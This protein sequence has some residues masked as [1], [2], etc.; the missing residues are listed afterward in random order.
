MFSNAYLSFFNTFYI[1]KSIQVRNKVNTRNKQQPPSFL[2]PNKHSFQ[3]T[4]VSSFS[5]MSFDNQQQQQPYSK[6]LLLNYYSESLLNKFIIKRRNNFNSFRLNYK[7][8]IGNGTGNERVK[9]SRSTGSSFY[10]R[11]I[12]NGSINYGKSDKCF[13]CVSHVTSPKSKIHFKNIVYNG[14]VNDGVNIKKKIYVL[15]KKKFDDGKEY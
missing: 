10:K 7:E 11:T 6:K 5:K 1:D 9:M 4:S 12:K 14:K 2:S 8:C 15:L 3:S 13:K